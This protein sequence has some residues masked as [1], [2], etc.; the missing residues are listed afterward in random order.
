MEHFLCEC[1]FYSELL[2]NRLGDV[3]TRQLNT[4][5]VDL[6]LRVKL[7]QTNIIFYI[8]HPSI[9]LIIPDRSTLNT[10]LLLILEIKRDIIYR[11]MNLPPSAQQVTAPQHQAAHL[12]STI[13]RLRSCLQYIKIIKYSKAIESNLD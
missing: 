12:N 7:G 10:L 8:P 5:A 11:R 9:L 4:K 2:W 1:E 6:V 3:L 13:R